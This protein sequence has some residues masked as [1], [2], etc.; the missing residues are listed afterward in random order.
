MGKTAGSFK[1]TGAFPR[2]VE[3]VILI[4]GGLGFIGA[5]TAAALA[6]LG[7][8]CVLG[9]HRR[10][11]LPDFLMANGGEQLVVEPLDCTD[12]RTI[13]DIGERHDITGIVHL[14]APDVGAEPVA[15]ID[16]YVRG[17]LN[18]WRRPLAG[19]C[20]ECRSPAPSGSTTGF[21]RRCS[22]KNWRSR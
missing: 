6:D 4:T 15:A 2:T 14:A 18:A 16:G 20:R 19:R 17:L 8:S 21:P 1:T 3:A 5:H 9:R 7:Q 11:G 12:L 10:S 13:T 22:S